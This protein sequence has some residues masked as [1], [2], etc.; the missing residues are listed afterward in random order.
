M[1]SVL[2]D[3]AGHRRSP[4]TM[5]GYHRGRPPRN[6]GEQYPADPPRVEEIV[7]VMSAVGDRADGHPLRVLVV[8]LWRAG[9]RISEALSLQESDLDRPAVRY[10]SVAGRVASDARSG[11]TAGES[12][13]INRHGEGDENAL[14]RRRSELRWPRVMRWR[15]VRAQ[16]SV[17][18]GRAGG[19]I[20]PRNS[21]EVQGADAF[22]CVRKAIPLAALFA[23]RWRTLRGRRSQ[24]RATSSMRENREISWSPARCW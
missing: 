20:E 4:A 12:A 13:G 5:P 3:V 21:I 15:S 9:L 10:S 2:L 11:W 1:E 23:S 7:A 19:V 17:D 16:R 6:K 14:H 22:P 24:A 8:L 18:R